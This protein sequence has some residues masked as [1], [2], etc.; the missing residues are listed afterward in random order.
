MTDDHQLRVCAWD[1]SP[2]RDDEVAAATGD[3]VVLLDTTDK[4]WYKVKVHRSGGGG[5]GSEGFLPCAYLRLLTRSDRIPSSISSDSRAVRN[6]TFSYAS[7]AP[8]ELSIIKGEIVAVLE[9]HGDG[10]CRVR[11]LAKDVDGLVPENHLA[12]PFSGTTHSCTA[13]TEDTPSAGAGEELATHLD[14]RRK[15]ISARNVI[16]SVGASA[17]QRSVSI[18]EN[19]EVDDSVDGGSSPSTSLQKGSSSSTAKLSTLASHAQ[20]QQKHPD[21]IEGI[22]SDAGSLKT[23]SGHSA[24]T[25][26]GETELQKAA[27]ELLSWLDTVGKGYAQRYGKTLIDE[28]YDNLHELADATQEDL[29]ELNPVAETCVDDIWTISPDARKRYENFFLNLAGKDGKG[30]HALLTF[31][32]VFPF[33]QKSGLQD[34]EISSVLALADCKTNDN[35]LNVDEFCVAFHI[36][37]VIARTEKS[38]G[39]PTTLPISLLREVTPKVT[40][41]S[42]NGID[43]DGI[44]GDNVETSNSSANSS[45]ASSGS[46]NGES[47][48]QHQMSS[49]TYANVR[50]IDSRF[51][52]HPPK[53][54]QAGLARAASVASNTAVPSASKSTPTKIKNKSFSRK[55]FNFIDKK[56]VAGDIESEGDSDGLLVAAR[57]AGSRA[58][59]LLVRKKEKK[60]LSST[61]WKKRRVI[62]SGARIRI[63]RATGNAEPS[64]E[65]LLQADSIVEIFTNDKKDT[66]QFGFTITKLLEIPGPVHREVFTARVGNKASALKWIEAL[67]SAITQLQESSPRPSGGDDPMTERFPGELDH[68]SYLAQADLVTTPNARP[69]STRVPTANVTSS[70]PRAVAQGIT[71]ITGGTSA[72]VPSGGSSKTYDESVPPHVSTLNTNQQENTLSSVVTGRNSTMGRAS[73]VDIGAHADLQK[74]DRSCRLFNEVLDAIT[75]AADLNAEMVL[76]LRAELTASEGALARELSAGCSNEER[77][78][79]IEVVRNRISTALR[80]YSFAQSA[81]SHSDAGTNNAGHMS[82]V[83]GEMT[84][85]TKRRSMHER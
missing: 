73:L 2:Q 27:R 82:R 76:E 12:K 48:A 70:T 1:Y 52:S 24:E 35:M 56:L 3:I 69:L 31:A 5:V 59:W 58:D 25:V 54:A 4:D 20:Q 61:N 44:F 64:Q 77:S 51:P 13:G 18:Q 29:I 19:G 42:F 53:L 30:A 45:A 40:T 72:S 6:V 37:G 78:A 15:S 16:E 79:S 14:K 68:Q 22:E 67:K 81:F 71:P 28:G 17:P 33:F 32:S 83:I 26:R 60:A 57:A 50:G 10:W 38:L 7:A 47:S 8:D 62:F 9:S 80:H 74:I 36:A 21:T 84:T 65:L 41:L 39:V 55:A 34:T 23:I 66:A 46:K 75:G 11:N 63:Y 49:Q 85:R 43:L